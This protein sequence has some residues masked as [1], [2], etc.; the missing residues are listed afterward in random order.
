MKKNNYFLLALTLFTIGA[1]TEEKVPQSIA[2]SWQ[3]KYDIEENSLV[4]SVA[5]SND[6]NMCLDDIFTSDTLRRQAANYEKR[7][8]GAPIKG[9]WKHLN[10]ENLP[11][12]Q[13]RFLKNFGDSIGDQAN[14]NSIN[15]EGCSS[16]PC[17]FNRIY[18]RDEFDVAGYVHYIWYLKFGVYLSLDNKVP[19]QVSTT[20]G[21]FNHKN[22][23]VSDYLYNNDELFGFWRVTHMLEEPYTS[24][25]N[26]KEI[27]RLPGKEAFEEERFKGACGLASS[28]GNIRLTSACLRIFR[29]DMPNSFLYIGLIHEMTHM[30]DYLQGKQGKNNEY[31]RSTQQDYIDLVGFVKQEYVNSNNE[32]VI[33]WS[34]KP[35]T[36]IIRDYSGETPIENFADTLAYFRQEGDETKTKITPA[37]FRWVSANYFQG[38]SFDK[39]GNRSWLL[40]KYEKVFFKNILNTVVTCSS[41][42]NK[43]IS[44]YFSS[45]DFSKNN[46][47]SNML[48]CLS[49]EAEAM[50]IRMTAHI[51]IYEPDGCR[52]ILKPDDKK[53]WNYTVKESLKKQFSV[54]VNEIFNDPEYLSRVKDFGQTLKNRSM[55]NQA[56]LECYN[57]NAQENLSTCYDL[58]VIEVSKKAALDLH[59]SEQQAQEMSLLYL[60]SYP[61]GSVSQDLFLSY[62]T[63]LN[64]HESLILEEAQD[65]WKMCLNTPHS[66]ELK[67]SGNLFYPRKG[68]LIS[69]IYNCLNTQLPSSLNGIIKAVSFDGE[70]ITHPVEEKIMLEFLAPMLNER[71]YSMHESSMDEESE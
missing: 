34:V 64:N 17:I 24:L 46:M 71:L 68:Y 54:Y 33:S 62:R 36:K 1:C 22:F 18:Q 43:F 4:R 8:T 60:N 61:Y 38:E 66:D 48:N 25:S 31:F 51:Q 30:L 9:Q 5:S 16:L 45:N 6:S 44:N 58:K 19:E 39:Q 23:K 10:L 27:Q 2:N 67:P 57:G 3:A 69:S 40:K 29:N 35:G 42:Q 13:A 63:I 59:I 11:I 47:N 15:Y 41:S 20:P 70:K 49:A 28:Y 21:V 7:I 26:L 65:L 56:L 52:T 50:A 12:A 32:L 53:L 37:Q 55:A 14:P